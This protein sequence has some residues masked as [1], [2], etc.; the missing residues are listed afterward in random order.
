MGIPMLFVQ[1]WLM[2][3]ALLPVIIIETLV[4]RRKIRMPLG[5]A[6]GGV[7]AANIP[8]NDTADFLNNH[9]LASVRIVV[10]ARESEHILR[11]PDGTALLTVADNTLELYRATPK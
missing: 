6:V 8:F 1:W 7:V 10:G 9:R 4:V 5:Q 11:D 3:C 2:A